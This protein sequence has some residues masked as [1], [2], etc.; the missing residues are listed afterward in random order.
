MSWYNDDEAMSEE[1]FTENAEPGEVDLRQSTTGALVRMSKRVG[2]WAQ[3]QR[4]LNFIDSTA[5]GTLPAQWSTP[6]LINGLVPGTGASQRVG[7]QIVMNF[8]RTRYI[9]AV[10]LS[11]CRFVLVYDS[12][13]NGAAPAIT[14][15]F[16]TN[17]YG[18]EVNW[19][20]R[21]RFLF[22]QD[23]TIPCDGDSHLEHEIETELETNYNAGTAG[24][25][26]DIATGALYF[27]CNDSSATGSAFQ[28]YIR[29][30]YE[31]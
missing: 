4:S 9:C 6:L 18:S 30:E 16:E 20:N 23:V 12:Q 11:A 22:I 31:E 7:R 14:D 8:I 28:A 24:T 13:S 2:G 25:V 19:S 1:G 26:A 10:S 15:I 21:D 3:T 27:L 5:S 29:L 17:T